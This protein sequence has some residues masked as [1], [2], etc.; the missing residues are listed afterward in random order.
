MRALIDEPLQGMAWW[1]MPSPSTSCK[2][3]EAGTWT[4]GG[5]SILGFNTVLAS[6][7][8]QGAV[9]GTTAT[10]D[11]SQLI[12]QDEFGTPLFEGAAYRF[13]VRLYPGDLHCAGKLDEV[14]A[15]VEREKPAHTL[16]DLCVIESGLRVGYQASLGIDTL[17]GGGPAEPGP[18]GESALVLGGQPT[19]ADRRGQPR[20]H[21]CATVIDIRR[22]HMQDDSVE[23]DA[24]RSFLA[25]ATS[26]VSCSMFVISSPSKPTESGSNGCSIAWSMASASYAGWTCR[27]AMTI[28]A[29]S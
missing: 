27:S 11:R 21:G 14:R 18:L 13:L 5:D 29:S 23:S 16:Y 8:P 24:L 4:D 25:R 6:A 20:G 9:L 12:T 7:E 1:A 10:F 2:P 19:W 15:I 22:T 28:T 26:T 17:L 3:S